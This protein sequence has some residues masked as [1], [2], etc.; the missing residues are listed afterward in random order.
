MKIKVLNSNSNGNCYILENDKS[1]LVIECG[2]AFSE[3]K[4]GLNFNTSKI[5][6]LVV[7]HE[8]L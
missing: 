7:T 2:V 1:C 3:I 8:H 6:M 5:D 4:K